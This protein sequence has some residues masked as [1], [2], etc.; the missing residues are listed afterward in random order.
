MAR[1]YAS[2]SRT[3][4]VP[5]TIARPFNNYG[6]GLKITDHRVIPDLARDIFEDRDLRCSRTARQRR[7]FCY[8]TDAVA[9]T[10]KSSSTAGPRALQRR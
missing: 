4:R 5:V 7:T 8:I 3:V 10:T 2:T 6:P 1:L 9:A